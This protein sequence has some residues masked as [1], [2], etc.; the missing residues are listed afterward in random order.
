M[1]AEILNTIRDISR[2][3]PVFHNNLQLAL[4][5]GPFRAFYLNP[6]NVCDLAGAASTADGKE[7]QAIFEEPNVETR[8]QRSLGLL[9]RK[10]SLS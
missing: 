4:D 9:E 2:M 1:T 10:A 3:N 6:V 7:L 8:L 5:N